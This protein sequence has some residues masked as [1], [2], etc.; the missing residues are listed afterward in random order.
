MSEA[1]TMIPSNIKIS[2]QKVKSHQDKT[3]PQ[4]ELE[5]SEKLNIEADKVATEIRDFIGPMQPYPSLK[6]DGITILKEDNIPTTNIHQLVLMK[7]KG[8]ELKEY[9]CEIHKWNE[10]TFQLIN[11]EGIGNTLNTSNHV[12]SLNLVQLIHNWQHDGQQKQLFELTKRQQQRIQTKTTLTI[13]ELETETKEL[14]KIAQCPFCTNQ[15]THQHYLHCTAPEIVQHRK[16]LKK[17]I[18]QNLQ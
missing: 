11:W 7:T 4:H 10:H 15:E 16:K 13:A 5:I 3:K 18:K 17:D 8:I 9:L 14:E 6:Y 1:Y 12:Q 2:F